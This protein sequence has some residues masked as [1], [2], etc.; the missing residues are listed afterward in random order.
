MVKHKVSHSLSSV[1][2]AEGLCEQTWCLR[3]HLFIFLLPKTNLG[4]GVF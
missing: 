4:S 1:M 3:D 2:L